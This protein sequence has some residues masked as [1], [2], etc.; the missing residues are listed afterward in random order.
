MPG[1]IHII[2]VENDASE[3]NRALKVQGCNA[4][5]LQVRP[6]E[7][8][9]QGVEAGSVSGDGRCQRMKV[10]GSDRHIIQS[11]GD[12]LGGQRVSLRLHPRLGGIPIQGI[13]EV[14]CIDL[15][16]RCASQQ[17]PHSRR[18]NTAR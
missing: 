12:R 1:F 18:I 9:F 14:G 16:I 5:L 3:V 4:H 11:D 7:P 17:V 6:L 8:S 13:R 2:I 10:I 15:L